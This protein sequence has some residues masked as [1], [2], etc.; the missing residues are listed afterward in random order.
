M[1]KIGK[2]VTRGGELQ[3]KSF[4]ESDN[5]NRTFNNA[6]DQTTTSQSTSYS[7]QMVN[8]QKRK[9]FSVFT[10]S[11]APTRGQSMTSSKQ[12]S[13]HMANPNP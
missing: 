3:W 5:F 12:K 4:R 13:F 9:T 11:Q 7:R 2:L 10:P 8:S 6:G 1:F